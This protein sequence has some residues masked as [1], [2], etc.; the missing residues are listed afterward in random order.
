M[1]KTTRA[2][3]VL[4][5]RLDT[6]ENTMK[7]LHYR[8]FAFLTAVILP[9]LAAAPATAQ[10]GGMMGQQGMGATQER[11]EAARE[12]CPCPMMQHR[13]AGM[14]RGM[15]AEMG[16]MMGHMA[17]DQE[18]IDLAGIELTAEQRAQVREL[19]QSHRRQHFERMARAINLRDDL[20]ALMQEETPDPNAVQRL[21]ARMAEIHGEMLADNVRLRNSVRE[22]LTVEQR[23]A[24]SRSTEAAALEEA[25]EAHH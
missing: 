18:G 6:T 12:G 4:L 2:S 5:H 15:G 8:H 3:I 16:G 24:L 7:A 9:L 22:V 23:Q 14:R 13:A 11:R 1:R 21:H 10:G 19:R 25:H 17:M 20:Q